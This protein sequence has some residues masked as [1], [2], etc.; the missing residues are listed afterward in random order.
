M[1]C[2]FLN[3][4]NRLKLGSRIL[5]FR[6]RMT[7]KIIQVTYVYFLCFITLANTFK[8]QFRKGMVLQ[9]FLERLKVIEFW[10]P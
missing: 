4:N 9:N 3:K 7:K 10:L 5:G 8:I 2:L 6:I 1:K